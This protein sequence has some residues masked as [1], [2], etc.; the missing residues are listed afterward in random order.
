[1]PHES[2]LV[3]P[4]GRDIKDS[5]IAALATRQFGVVGCA[6][7]AEMGLTAKAIRHRVRTGRLHALHRGVYAVGHRVVPRE[8]RWMAAVLAS[9]NGA[10]LSHRSA[11]ELWGIRKQGG[12][13][14]EVTTPAWR[15]RVDGIVRHTSS[16]MP[17]DEVTEHRGIPTTTVP[18]TLLDLA[19]VL[20]P[21]EIHR[22]VSE[23]E[24][25]RL[26]DHLSVPELLTRYPRRRG[27]AKLRAALDH[28]ATVT[29]S[30]LEARFES[31]V[32]AHRLPRPT[33]NVV[34]HGYEL[35]AVWPH[36]KLAVELD[37]Y[38]THGT[39]ARFESDRERDRA[40]TAMGWRIIRIT[41]RQLEH[42]AP[43][44]AQDLRRLLAVR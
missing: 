20:R 35:D 1:M 7:L 42:D 38:A 11:A 31:F 18:R 30:E 37:G 34:V 12:P 17:F 26:T 44:V 39:R 32:E 19:A 3:A 9:G 33:L 16:L 2:N 4:I 10:V 28:G 25:H 41:W 24:I 23:A 43:A 14:S 22:A 6:Q 13:T 15:P 27:T 5:S 40:L 36:H 21:Q 29:R 8:G